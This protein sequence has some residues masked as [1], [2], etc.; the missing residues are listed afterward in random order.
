MSSGRDFTAGELR[1]F[2]DEFIRRAKAQDL[3]ARKC[4]QL[5]SMFEQ[6]KRKRTAKTKEAFAKEISQWISTE[7]IVSGSFNAK[8]KSAES[9]SLHNERHTTI[10]ISKSSKVIFDHIVKSMDV[11]SKKEAFL[12]LME[13][14]IKH[15]Y[16]LYGTGL[17]PLA[18]EDVDTD[19][20][21]TNW[22]RR[23]ED[24]INDEEWDDYED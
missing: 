8:V 13:S 14:Y 1:R 15:E 3:G 10:Q 5:Q 11:S 16:K 9:K 18:I 7:M 2:S 20:V 4:N 17:D 12:K 19:A 23:L 24:M 21:P 6:L 22:E